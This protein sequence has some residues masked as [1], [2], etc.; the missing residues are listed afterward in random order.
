[1]KS[2]ISK[3]KLEKSWL[4]KSKILKFGNMVLILR[5]TKEKYIFLRYPVYIDHVHKASIISI[6][7]IQNLI[8]E[9]TWNIWIALSTKCTLSRQL[10]CRISF[11]STFFS[12][13]SLVSVFCLETTELMNKVCI[14]KKVIC[15]LINI[16]LSLGLKIT[17]N[18]LFCF[19]VN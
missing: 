15:I 6:L 1:M 14:L 11:L 2:N 4:G 7:K 18:E 3:F 19:L 9:K 8:M 13:L 16:I 12:F 10:R 17:Y 5:S